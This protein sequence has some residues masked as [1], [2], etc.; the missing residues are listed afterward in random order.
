MRR[1]LLSTAAIGLCVGLAAG[2]G[3]D[4]ARAILDKA[5]K[6]HGG[7]DAL[8]KYKAG[9]IKAKGRVEVAGGIDIVQEI[10]YQLPNLMREEGSFE[11]M[12]TPIKTVTIYDGKKASLEVNGKKIDFGEKLERALRD[13]VQMFD[14]FSLYPLNDKAYELSV[15]GEEKVNGEAAIG[16][17]AVRKGQPDM[18]LY[19]DKKTHLLVKASHRTVDVESGNEVTQD[20]IVTEYQK[21]DGIPQPKKLLVERDGKKFLEAEVVEMKR[22]ESLDKERFTIPQ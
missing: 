1:L 5:I 14:A 11:V 22:Y 21:V 12:G 8:K 7:T 13:G 9:T 16:I 3:Q 4:E 10:S 6:A 2:Q 17:R 20:R 19:F 18:T 15:F